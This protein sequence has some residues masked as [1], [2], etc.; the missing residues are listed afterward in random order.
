MYGGVVGFEDD[1]VLKWWQ[2]AEFRLLGVVIANINGRSVQFN[3]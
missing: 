1:C 3:S 2:L